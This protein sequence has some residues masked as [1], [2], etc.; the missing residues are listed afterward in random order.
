MK[1]IHNFIQGLIKIKVALL[2]LLI[3]LIGG[4][5]GWAQTANTRMDFLQA[6][7]HARS[8][9]MAGATVALRYHP[10]GAVVNPAVIGNPGQVV[11][12]SQINN[13]RGPIFGRRPK[14]NFSTDIHYY[15]P[16]L[17]VSPGQ[18]SVGY[19]YNRFDYGERT[20]VGPTGEMLGHYRS[21]EQAHS[22]TGAYHYENDLSVGTGIHI[23]K[24]K[25]LPSGLDVAGQ[26]PK[27]PTTV[28][29]DLGIYKGYSYEI[30]DK[31][32]L[33]PSIGCSLTDLGGSIAYHEED[34]GHPV[35]MTMRGGAGVRLDH[36][37][38]RD[39]LE[40]YPV[41]KLFSVGI[42]LSYG[43][44]LARTDDG[45]EPMSPFK[46]LF[47]AWDSYTINNGRQQINISLADQLVRRS[48]LE[49]TLVNLFSLRYGVS[50]SNRWVS[51]GDRNTFGMGFHY[52]YVTLDY[53]SS[54]PAEDEGVEKF[55][56]LSAYDYLQFKVNL[57]FEQIQKWLDR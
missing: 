4:V 44:Q 21:F 16:A 49:L 35:P 31:L 41:R 36:R 27:N 18:W 1:R 11:L 52:K 28:T 33:R 55:T 22:L 37:A 10:A 24:N 29:F 54:S 2:S 48:G 43:K 20:H 15:M 7:H 45:G 38:D 26:N 5:G 51:S 40:F 19:Q 39:Y 3:M 25:M 14:T 42:Y 6:N 56:H 8:M 23:A 17:S 12:T 50:R 9:G 32:E 30:D 46:A 53:V 34:D 13:E 57:P 47:N